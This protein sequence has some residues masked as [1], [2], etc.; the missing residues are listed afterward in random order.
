[1]P[2][3]NPDALVPV[4]IVSGSGIPVCTEGWMFEP[5]A[6]S[7]TARYIID[8]KQ[9]QEFKASLISVTCVKTKT[10]SLSQLCISVS[11]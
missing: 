2:I 8:I 6:H 7:V 1:M 10:V 4:F 11:E 3:G 9:A 5:K